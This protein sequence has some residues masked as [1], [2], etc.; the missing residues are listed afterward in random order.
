[1]REPSV[2]AG[3]TTSEFWLTLAGQ[4]IAF[5]V[6]LGVVGA[7]DEATVTNAVAEAVKH[8]FALIAAAGVLWKYIQ[9]RAQIKSAALSRVMLLL[10]ALFG[11]SVCGSTEAQT[12]TAV[13]VTNLS[14]GTYLLTKNGAAVA[15]NP[16]NLIRPT[17]SPLPTPGG[18]Q[19][20]F[21]RTVSR[22]TSEALA[23]GGT[24]TTAAGIASVYSLVSESVAKGDI[25][26]E[27]ALEA[28]GAGIRLVMTKSPDSAKWVAFRTTLGDALDTLRQ[29]G[30][31]ATKAQYVKVL[32]EVANGMN[33][34]T[35]FNGSLSDPGERADPDAILGGIDIAKIIELIKLLLELFKLFK[36]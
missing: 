1:M 30:S 32:Q 22:L 12:I 31:L 24:T 11:M 17:N 34:V 19:T 29:D 35:G 10:V 2:K 18:P 4:I 26:P 28:V 25:A 16:I 7:D 33:S 15:V 6:L 21:E 5:L 27:R 23:A 13:D 9:G 36:P 20:P 8:S 14:D 3:W